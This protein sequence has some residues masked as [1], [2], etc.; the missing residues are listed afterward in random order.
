[1]TSAVVR[2]LPVVHVH[3]GPGPGGCAQV[4]V[5]HGPLLTSATAPASTVDLAAVLPE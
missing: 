5:E 1:M 3:R 4:T 2:L